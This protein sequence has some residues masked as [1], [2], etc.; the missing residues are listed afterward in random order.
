VAE[1]RLQSLYKEKVFEGESQKGELV[2]LENLLTKLQKEYEIKR[3]TES[4][5][6]LSDKMSPGIKTSPE[7][8]R[9]MK[10]LV[11]EG[12]I[13]VEEKIRRL[14]LNPSG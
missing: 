4:L 3:K 13:L 8:F 1:Y 5:S 2:A 7:Y 9:G 11:L 10:D 14:K 12:I 6:A